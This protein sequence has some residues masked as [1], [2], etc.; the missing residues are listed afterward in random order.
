MLPQVPQK[1]DEIVTSK[2]VDEYTSIDVVSRVR[3]FFPNELLEGQI[4]STG[5]V[6]AEVW[7]K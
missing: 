6:W 2:D 7:L 1:G 4:I 3:W 5:E